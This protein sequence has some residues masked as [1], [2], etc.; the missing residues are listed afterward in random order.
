MINVSAVSSTWLLN[1]YRDQTMQKM[2]QYCGAFH[3]IASPYLGGTGVLSWCAQDAK[4]VEL[5]LLQRIVKRYAG[6]DN[7]VDFLEPHGELKHG[8]YDIFLEY[9]PVADRSYRTFLKEK[10]RS[11]GRLSAVVRTSGSHPELGGRPC[12]GGGVVSRLGR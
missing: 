8:D 10:Y 7:V 4:D 2:P 6:Q 9:G 3:S 12:A 11:T 5:S 1:R